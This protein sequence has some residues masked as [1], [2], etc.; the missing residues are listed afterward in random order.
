V[1]RASITP[2][3]HSHMQRNMQRAASFN[4]TLWTQSHPA[5]HAASCELQL[6]P[7]NTVTSSGT[8]SKLRASITP[9]EHSHMQRNM[10]HAASFNYTLWHQSWGCFYGPPVFIFYFTSPLAN[11]YID[12]N[13]Q[14]PSHRQHWVLL[15]LV[16]Y[17]S[18]VILF[19][20]SHM[21]N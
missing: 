15:L 11:L 6:H 3:E 7:V 1:L 16:N 8:C 17:R 18:I 20:V 5:A 10:Q 21:L 12:A 14:F 13:V 4:Y 19:I 9:C 2:C